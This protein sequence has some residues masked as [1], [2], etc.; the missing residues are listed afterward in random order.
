[1][2]YFT[3]LSSYAS[4]KSL[5]LDFVRNLA[6]SPR[7]QKALRVGAALTLVIGT[8]RL[9]TQLALNNLSRT[10]DW[11]WSEDIVM[12][13]GGC[14]GIGELVCRKLASHGI[15]VVAVDLQ[16][17]Q[18]P[19]P[20]NIFYYR[21]DVTSSQYISQIAKSIRQAVGEPTVLINNAGVASLKTILGE[22]EE[23][24]R[25]T[26]DVNVVAHFLLAREFLPWMIRQD[27]GH[28][29]T[30]ASMAS[31]ITVASGVDYCASKAA[32]LAFHEGL[33][34]ELKYK[35]NAKHVRT[36]SIAPGRYYRSLN[37]TC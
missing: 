28:I 5:N 31:Y 16:P 13:T 7:F 23:D 29:I 15:K 34:Q 6:S 32:A 11:D 10:H 3:A 24:I 37:L 1:M 12:V 2:N 33:A 17:P 19:F 18:V 26:F 30:I 27:H 22:S 9:L 4:S 25:R 8:N 35:Y 21:L 36:R 14:N 20:D